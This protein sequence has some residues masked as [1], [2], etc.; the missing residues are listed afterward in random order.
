[1]SNILIQL[2]DYDGNKL[3]PLT[4]SASSFF[5]DVECK[6]AFI[7]KMNEKAASLGMSS[8]T[9]IN[10]SG[11]G[12]S[13]NYSKT[14]VRDLARMM[15][16]ALSYNRLLKIWNKSKYSVRVKNKSDIS[17]TTSVTSPSLENY[18]PILGGK[19]GGG[20]GHLAL[21]IATVVE[22]I[23]VVGAISEVSTGNPDD[24]FVAMKQLFDAV[25]V[26]IQGGTPS[27]RAVTVAN[28]ACAYLVPN[29]N[30]ATVEDS[31]L[32]SCLYEQNAD[33]ATIPMST[34]KV[35]TIITALD[36]IY[37]IHV[38][39]II[40]PLDV[41]RT[42]GTSGSIFSVGDIVSLEDL[43]YAAMLLSSNQAANAIARYAG[44]KILAESNFIN[45]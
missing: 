11:L 5:T 9:W 25:K 14:S 26:K 23:P 24:R 32:L 40:K 2:E 39:V 44:Q 4:P 45:I 22:N 10:P 30:T 41:E 8:T 28:C 33:K 17:I 37:D 34:T 16:E 7:S 42:Q 20:D 29:Y 31:N 43:M 12:E 1:M 38:P 6:N 21:V 18:Y 15:I 3:F 19:T 35:M 27:Q 36:Y 13:G